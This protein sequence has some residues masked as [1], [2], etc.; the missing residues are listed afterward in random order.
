M[1]WRR[2]VTGAVCLPIAGLG[3]P[4]LVAA[5][6]VAVCGTGSEAGTQVTPPQRSVPGRGRPLLLLSPKAP[7]TLE[8]TEPDP[9][10]AYIVEHG[11]VGGK[12]E[13][14]IKQKLDSLP[15]SVGTNGV[16]PLDDRVCLSLLTRA[17]QS[18]YLLVGP[19]GYPLNTRA[20]RPKSSM[21]K[22]GSKHGSGM[23]SR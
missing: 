22:A 19:P 17:D 23:R 9:T 11:S 18:D 16:S 20:E 8:T 14:F 15:A 3:L 10:H 12:K 5:S 1:A 2:L 6:L 4:A 13:S 7:A 21:T